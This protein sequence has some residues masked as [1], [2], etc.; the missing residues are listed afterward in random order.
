MSGTYCGV[1]EGMLEPGN[2]D[3]NTRLLVRNPDGLVPSMVVDI[4]G[5]QILLPARSP[6]GRIMPSDEA[7]AEYRRT[8]RHLGKFS[9]LQAANEYAQQLH[10]NQAK[11]PTD[12]DLEFYKLHRAH[13]VALNNATA[14]Y[15]QSLIRLIL[16][17]NAASIGG[18]L[19]LIGPKDSNVS[20]GPVGV[21]WA[22]YSWG[23][24]ILAAILATCF[25][26]WSQRKF[27]Q[28]YRSR[29]LAMELFKAPPG[30]CAGVERSKMY[31]L[32]MKKV[33]N[34]KVPKTAQEYC[35]DADSLRKGADSWQTAAI[36]LGVVAVILSIVGFC[37]A[38]YSIDTRTS[39]QPQKRSYFYFGFLP[40]SMP[41]DDI[42]TIDLTGKRTGRA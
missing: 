20:F 37:F 8:S 15:E 27:T 14:T 39:P 41:L 35:D 25:A 9:S 40:S 22:I 2:I 6:D 19:A 11:P 29:R 1:P 12:F 31:G 38:I 17:L 10:E 26:Y 3:L 24:G 32:A 18:L 21:R 36:I 34:S 30:D 16:I 28:A 23:F 13:E 4:D 5:K 7:I 42:G 33:N